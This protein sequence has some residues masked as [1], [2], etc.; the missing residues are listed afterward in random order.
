MPSWINFIAGVVCIGCAVWFFYNAFRSI[1]RFTTMRS[2]S[3]SYLVW[4]HEHS[5][6]WR[7]ARQ[8]YT[9][10]LERAG[11]YTRDEALAICIQRD[12]FDPSK[13]PYE[14]PV[15]EEDA[16]ACAAAAVAEAKLNAA[17]R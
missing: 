16:L 14:I 7:P 10:F 9:T 15:R 12:G 8:G 11:R 2:L 5:A 17:M 13:A 6:W 3:N 4:S 1:I